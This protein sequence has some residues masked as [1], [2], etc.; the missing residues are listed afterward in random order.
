MPT[1]SKPADWNDAYVWPQ[2]GEAEVPHETK[3]YE[4]TG[5]ASVDGHAPGTT[6]S[7]AL[8]PTREGLLLAGGHLRVKESLEDLKAAARELDISGRS[9]MSEEELKRAVEEARAAQQTATPAEQVNPTLLHPTADPA[10]TA[11]PQQPEQ[12]T[13]EEG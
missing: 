12:T 13:P 10:A 1:P 2:P 4:V 11:D 9:K 3:E 7:A 8:D 6:F 5:T